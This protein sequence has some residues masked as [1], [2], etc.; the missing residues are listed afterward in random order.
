MNTRTAEEAKE[1]YIAVMG[2]PLGA[3]FHSL[4]QELAWLFRKWDNYVALFGSK[5]SRVDLLNK[6]APGFF[7]I[8]QDALWEG[9]L[10]HIARLTDP[11][12]SV[13][14][15]N[16]TTQRLHLLVTDTA[17]AQRVKV[18]T[19]KAIEAATFCRDWRN[20]RIAHSD[21]SLAV[22]SHPIPLAPASREHV[23]VALNSL[24]EV[25][26]AVTK[27]YMDT[28]TVFDLGYQGDVVSLLYTLDDGLRGQA[29]RRT[30]LERGETRDDD[31]HRRD[32]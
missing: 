30:R 19:D 7:R 5:P 20:R 24:V 28:T 13:G 12:N 18:L 14:K 31:F 4:W 2:E 8:V 32:L 17:V 10:L 26:N 15:P 3:L 16:L 11:P 23:I 27:H 21:L 29:E 25:L 22:D 1:S 6:S 9:I